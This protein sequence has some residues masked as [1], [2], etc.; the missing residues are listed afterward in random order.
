M[1]GNEQ[2]VGT[3]HVPTYFQ[4]VANLRVIGCRFF[5]EVQNLHIVEKGF[6]CRLVL[7]PS[8]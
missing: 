6:Q 3:D 7:L 8:W 4:F 2:V 1:S 5:P